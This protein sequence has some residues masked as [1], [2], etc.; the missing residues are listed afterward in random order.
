MAKDK[1]DAK[2]K[3]LDLN[4]TEQ[5]VMKALAGIEKGDVNNTII[6]A[7]DSEDAT[8]AKI[9]DG[10][11]KSDD[12]YEMNDDKDKKED[13]KKKK[14]KILKKKVVDDDDKGDED[15]GDIEKAGE[16]QPL[17][18]H[19]KD[20]DVTPIL[21]SFQDATMKL[22][23]SVG[24]G[25][26][27]MDKVIAYMVDTNQKMATIFKGMF[28]NMMSLKAE[29]KE[30]K[31][32]FDEMAL[33]SQG[34]KSIGSEP[35]ERFDK[36]GVNDGAL[37]IVVNDPKTSKAHK[38]VIMKALETTLPAGTADTYE[39]DEDIMTARAISNYDLNAAPMPFNL[40]AKAQEI[41]GDQVQLR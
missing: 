20:I 15:K 2:N 13:K 22:D 18:E 14:K 8:N 19:Q 28:S 21:K 31:K 38:N 35:V 6:K 32:G 26:D 33:Q 30:L 36:S 16:S 11:D 12:G 10:K 23:K 9:E 3:G 5:D 27:K 1:K 7:D 37:S 39:K 17:S 29:N 41:L 24:A 40:I 4:V 34:R 25:N